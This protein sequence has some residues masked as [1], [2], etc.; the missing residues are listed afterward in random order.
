MIEV[1]SEELS[2]SW[3]QG[4]W[5]NY[6]SLNQKVGGVVGHTEP[7]ICMRGDLDA[8]HSVTIGM[9][10]IPITHTKSSSNLDLPYK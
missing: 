1:S 3:K 8:G 10:L 2:D 5:R 4:D 9:E 6:P 7:I